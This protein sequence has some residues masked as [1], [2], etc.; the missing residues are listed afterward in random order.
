MSTR[1][2]IDIPPDLLQAANIMQYANRQNLIARERINA[3]KSKA[4]FAIKQ[5][6]EDEGSDD[7]NKA[8]P[9]Y[10]DDDLSI[11]QSRDKMSWFCV[12]QEFEGSYTEDRNVGIYSYSINSSM[13]T[14]I[15]IGTWADEDDRFFQNVSNLSFVL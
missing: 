3:F 14:S 8:V 11:S 2:L 7:K 12:W 5:K 13:N 4:A 10:R 15:K 6:A 1:I 9:E